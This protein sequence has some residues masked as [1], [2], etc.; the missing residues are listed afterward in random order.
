MPAARKV[1]SLRGHESGWVS[2]SAEVQVQSNTMSSPM[3][4][5]LQ[6]KWP[7]TSAQTEQTREQALWFPR[8]RLCCL[9][10]REPSLFGGLF[11]LYTSRVVWCVVCRWRN[12]RSRSSGALALSGVSPPLSFPFTFLWPLKERLVVLLWRLLSCRDVLTRACLIAHHGS[13]SRRSR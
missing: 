12:A 11:F 13:K 1:C 6:C 9:V 8:I 7:S 4:C 2:I 3:Q 5:P 10:A